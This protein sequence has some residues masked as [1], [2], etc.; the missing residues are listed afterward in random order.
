[1]HLL[2]ECSELIRFW[3][4]L[5]KFWPSISHKM[6]ENGNGGFLPLSEKLS[7]QSNSDLMCT[8][9]GWVFRIESLLGHVGQT[10]SEKCLKIVA[11]DHYQKSAIMWTYEYSIYFKHGVHTGERVIHKWNHFCRI[12]LICPLWWP[13]LYFH[14][15]WLG[16][17]RGRSSSDSLL[18]DGTKP[19]PALMEA[20]GDW[21]KKHV[22]IFGKLD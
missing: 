5:A 12:G 22:W 1:M 18:C 10:L 17:I 13:S 9:I 15:L 14:S 6:T 19:L 16:L 4:M 20:M 21:S 2:G 7:T 8:L 11:S 3:T